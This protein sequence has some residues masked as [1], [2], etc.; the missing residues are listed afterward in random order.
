MSS[1][2]V[3]FDIEFVS[4]NHAQDSSGVSK[5]KFD[6]FFAELQE[7]NDVL[8]LSPSRRAFVTNSKIAS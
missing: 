8:G 3:E 1:K 4:K 2:V 7:F 5:D 6:L